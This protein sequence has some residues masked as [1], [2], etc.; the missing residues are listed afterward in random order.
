MAQP[1]NIPRN[2]LCVLRSLSAGLILLAGCSFQACSTPG[3][4]SAPEG[5]ISPIVLETLDPTKSI[6]YS[7]GPIDRAVEAGAIEHVVVATPKSANTT[8]TAESRVYT[9]L[10]PRD[11]S[12]TIRIERTD[13]GGAFVAGARLL[14]L[15]IRIGQA[16]DPALETAVGASIRR[17]LIRAVEDAD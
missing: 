16:G 17:L 12:G 4:P 9:L 7:W 2:S 8:N 5:A 10:A 11:R 15:T 6:Y 1:L 3:L 13:D 14:S